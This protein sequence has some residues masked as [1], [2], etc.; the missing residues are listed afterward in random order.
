MSSPLPVSLSYTQLAL[1]LE[2]N[3]KKIFLCV[4]LGAHGSDMWMCEASALQ[5]ACIFTNRVIYNLQR[6]M[7]WQLIRKKGLHKLHYTLWMCCNRL[8]ST[9]CSLLPP[10]VDG[11]HCSFL[12]VTYP[13]T[14]PALLPCSH[15][16][17][18]FACQK[19]SNIH[20][21]A[22]EDNTWKLRKKKKKVRV[23]INQFPIFS[24]RGEKC[25]H[26][27]TPNWSNTKNQRNTKVHHQVSEWEGLY[28]C[29]FKDD[30][31]EFLLYAGLLNNQ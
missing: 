2:A 10:A 7:L 27:N 5:W 30:A 21:S 29:C 13:Q 23:S 16:V 19:K 1:S 25:L 9:Q 15:R 3:V 8:A 26:P 17:Q 14:G 20:L 31:T 6:L 28:L 11:A 22:A 24:R 18:I 4:S 12:G